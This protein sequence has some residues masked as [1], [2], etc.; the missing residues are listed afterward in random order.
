M[1]APRLA[2]PIRSTRFRQTTARRGVA[3]LGLPDGHLPAGLF[4]RGSVL[5]LV[6]RA[7]ALGRLRAA[8]QGRAQREHERPSTA[9]LIVLTG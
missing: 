7:A 3:F 9:L 1:T 6:P 4:G 5:V 2:V 8:L